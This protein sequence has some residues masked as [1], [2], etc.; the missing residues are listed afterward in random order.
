[1]ESEENIFYLDS[2]LFIPHII[3]KNISNIEKLFYKKKIVTILIKVIK[4]GD[5]RNFTSDC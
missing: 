3:D 1:M 5:E 2:I 4:E